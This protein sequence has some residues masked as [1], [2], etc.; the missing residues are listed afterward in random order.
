MRAGTYLGFVNTILLCMQIK[1]KHE[2]I[3]FFFLHL[4][5]FT[6]R[7]HSLNAKKNTVDR[8]VCCLAHAMFHIHF[9]LVF[10]K[11]TYSLA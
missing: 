3:H 2:I 4:L 10:K 1:R 7:D 8:T 5:R 9:C 11:K 6:F